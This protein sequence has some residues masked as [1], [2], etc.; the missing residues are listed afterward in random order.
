VELETCAG[1]KCTLLSFTRDCLFASSCRR[2]QFLLKFDTLYIGRPTFN[3]VEMSEYV[4]DG[5][6]SVIH[7]V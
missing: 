2:S 7:R 1:G 5:L 4:E 3:S 6:T